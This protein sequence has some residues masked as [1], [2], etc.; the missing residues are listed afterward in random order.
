[1]HRTN[2]NDREN[3][4]AEVYSR[5][6]TSLISRPTRVSDLIQAT[7]TDDAILSRKDWCSEVINDP[8]ATFGTNALV[9]VIAQ[10]IFM[11]STVVSFEWVHHSSNLLVE[12]SRVNELIRR[13]AGLNV[14]FTS[15][16]LKQLNQP[17]TP[18]AI[19]DMV[20]DAVELEKQ[21]IGGKIHLI[22]HACVITESTACQSLV[23]CFLNS[24]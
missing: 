16:A 19:T 20:R 13:D 7:E 17:P 15:I 6:L 1:M 21:F 18:A 8:R 5:F 10:S 2:Q 12:F 11:S 14:E 22:P 24:G 23:S 4:H 9:C 3:I